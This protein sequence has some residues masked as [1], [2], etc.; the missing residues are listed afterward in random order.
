[1]CDLVEFVGVLTKDPELADDGHD[2]S[3]EQPTTGGMLRD[4][5]VQ[6]TTSAR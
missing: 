4:S 1:M 6:E 3:A 5:V 2:D